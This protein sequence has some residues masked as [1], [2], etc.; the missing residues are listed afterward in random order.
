[1]HVQTIV[2]TNSVDASKQSAEQA[3]VQRVAHC[4]HAR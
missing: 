1:M 2:R 3:K 4:A